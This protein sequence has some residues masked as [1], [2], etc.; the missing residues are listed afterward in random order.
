MQKFI[1]DG[2]STMGA[3]QKNDA[4][5]SVDEVSTNK[6]KSGKKAKPGK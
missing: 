1:T 6:K 4:P 5:M 3:P 2:R